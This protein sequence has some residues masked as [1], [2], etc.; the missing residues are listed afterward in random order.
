MIEETKNG[1]QNNEHDNKKYENKQNSFHG[2]LH[3]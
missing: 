2:D 3:S 1:K